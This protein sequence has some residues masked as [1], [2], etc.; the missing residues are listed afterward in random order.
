MPCL[1]AYGAC[2]VG[3]N[4]PVYLHDNGALISAPTDGGMGYGPATGLFVLPVRKPTSDERK[5]LQADQKKRG[6]KMAEP[7]AQL[8]DFDIE[9]EYVVHN[10][11]AMTQTVVVALDGGNE[12]GDYVPADYIDPRA[13]QDEQPSPPHLVSDAPLT[14]PPGM[15]ATGIFREDNLREAAIDLEAIT[16]YPSA[17]GVLATPYEVIEHLSTV[18]RVGLEN[19]PAGDVTPAMVRYSLSATAEGQVSMDFTV[20]VRD[21]HGKLAAQGAKNLYVS[22]AATLTPPANPMPPDMM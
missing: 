15:S 21:H 10:L 2:V 19:V 8:G 17:A 20:R 13:N 6:L 14:I 7:W 9:I 4:D 12:F 5:K 3:C 11:D 22:T 16:R 18:S 1:V